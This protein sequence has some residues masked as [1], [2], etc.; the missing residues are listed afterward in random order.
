MD[1][2]NEASFQDA[3][4]PLDAMR[5]RP[6]IRRLTVAVSVVSLISWPVLFMFLV[7]SVMDETPTP[8][9]A[10]VT[11]IIGNLVWTCSVCLTYSI[12]FDMAERRWPAAKEVRSIVTPLLKKSGVS[13]PPHLAGV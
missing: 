11:L 7:V 6:T 4:Q 8:M 1:T 5:P 10:M 12:L 13:P 9:W 2:S 3:R